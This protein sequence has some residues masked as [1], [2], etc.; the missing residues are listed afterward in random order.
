MRPRT[1]TSFLPLDLGLK[2]PISEKRNTAS[3]LWHLSSRWEHHWK[4]IWRHQ[5]L[6]YFAVGLQISFL[7]RDVENCS[8]WLAVTCLLLPGHWNILLQ[9]ILKTLL[10]AKLLFAILQQMEGSY[11]LFGP[12]SAR[13]RSSTINGKLLPLCLFYTLPNTTAFSSIY[14]ILAC[15]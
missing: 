11:Q 1:Q 2:P 12:V 14:Q 5:D 8:V 13:L 4:D 3:C 6:L 9:W 15:F 10:V 7:S